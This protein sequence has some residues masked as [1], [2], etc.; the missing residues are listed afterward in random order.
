[1]KLQC[2]GGPRDGMRLPVPWPVDTAVIYDENPLDPFGESDA[3]VSLYTLVRWKFP[4]NPGGYSCWEWRLHYSNTY[5][6]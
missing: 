5:Q 2:I 6:R 1:M 4:P 3:K